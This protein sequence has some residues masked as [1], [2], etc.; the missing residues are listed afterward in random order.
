MMV[1]VLGAPDSG[2]TPLFNI[3]TGRQA[4]GGELTGEILY[5]GRKPTADFRRWVGYVVKEDPHLAHMTVF[6]TLYFSA[7]LRLPDMP[8]KIV[9]LR[10]AITLKLLG[11]SHVANSVVGDG[12][13]RGISGGEKRRVSF[14]IE[15][16]AGHA[17]IIADL[18]TNGLD[19][20]SA[21]SLM[22][23]MRFATKVGFSMMASVVQPSPQLLRLFHRVMVMSKGTIIYF[24]P[25]SQAEEFFLSAGFV[26]PKT[27]ALP[28]FIEEVTLKPELFY[29]TK[30]YKELQPDMYSPPEEEQKGEEQKQPSPSPAAAAPT[31]LPRASEPSATLPASATA[32]PAVD[33]RSTSPP[34]SAASADSNMSIVV[35][36]DGGKPVN[37]S[38][39]KD[40][41]TTQG[42]QNSI[43]ASLAELET[44]HKQLKWGEWVLPNTINRSRYHAFMVIYRAYK[45]SRFHKDVEQVLEDQDAKKARY[46]A[47]HPHKHSIYAAAKGMAYHQQPTHAAAT[48]AAPPVGGVNLAQQAQHGEDEPPARGWGPLGRMWYRQYNSSPWLQLWMNISRQT[49]LTIRNTGLWRDTWLTSL[50]MGFFLGSLFYQEGY[51]YQQ[52]RNRVGLF[53]FIL[54]YLAFN[55][56]MLVPVLAHQRGVYYNQ[57]AGGYYHGFA[58]YISHFIT[59]IPIVVVET[60]LLLLPVWGLGGLQG[61]DGGREFWYAYLVIGFNSLISRVWMILLASVS[62]NEVYADVLNTVTN[63]IF[64]K[65]CGYFI[66]ASNI[67]NGWYWVY[68]I[69]YFTYALRGLAKN[70]IWPLNDQ[71]CAQL[72]IDAQQPPC[73]DSKYETCNPAAYGNA[74]NPCIFQTGR[75]AL[76]NLYGIDPAIDK[77]SDFVN[78]VWFLLAFNVGAMLASTYVNWNEADEPE[79]PDFGNTMDLKHRQMH[80][81]IMKSGSKASQRTIS[82]S[83]NHKQ[84]EQGQGQGGS[85]VIPRAEDASMDTNTPATPS[86]PPS[87]RKPNSGANAEAAV[88]GLESGAVANAPEEGENE[89]HI[90]ANEM[91][92]SH[93][94]Q[95]MDIDRSRAPLKTKKA[96][97]QF[98]DL[99]YTVQVGKQG[100]GTEPRLL[101]NHCFG[102]AKPSMMTALMGASGAGKSTLLDVLAGKKTGGTISGDIL[103]NG[104]KADYAGS[105]SR[106]AGYVEQFDSHEAFQTVREAVKFSGR[107]RLPRKTTEKE[108]N[109][110]VDHVLEVLGISH[111]ANRMIGSPG[112]GGVSMEVR[113]KCTIAVELIM[114]PSL[115]FLDEPTTGLDSAG[116]IAV[117]TSMQL[118]AE[119]QGMT[120]VCTIHQPSAELAL[121]FDNIILMMPGGQVAYF[122]PFTMLPDWFNAHKLG[123]LQPGQNP[124]DFALDQVKKAQLGKNVDGEPVDM[125]DEFKNS[126]EAK[127]LLAE[128]DHG[129]MPEEEKRSYTPPVLAESQPTLVNQFRCLF[130]RFF[131][132]NMRNYSYI[133]IRIGLAVFM[134]FVVGTVFVKLGYDQQYS[135]QRVS[136]IFVTLIFVMFT[137]NAYL[138]DIFFLR[139][140]YFRET[141]SQM[142]SPLAFYM[143]RFV[144]DAPIVLVE[145]FILCV[146]VYFIVDLNQGNHASAFG[147][148]FLTMLGVRWTSVFFTWAIGTAV[149]LP[150]NANT[151]QSTYFNVQMILTGFIIPG[152]SIYNVWVWLY[153]ITYCHWAL[154]FLIANE[155]RSEQYQCDTDQL[156]PYSNSLNAGYCDLTDYDQP[157]ANNPMNP[158]N[159]NL[160]TVAG[161]DG[162]KCRYQCGYDLMQTYGVQWSYGKMAEYEL[163]L[164]GF[165]L[166]FAVVA[167]FALAYINHI[168]R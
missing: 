108:L 9:R 79:H 33:D 101:L 23:T 109:A 56:V 167:A 139:P 165:G 37:G 4:H 100:G 157:F 30:K 3:L 50:V 77:W 160:A 27:K 69:S 155:S 73:T 72:A 153:D 168:K 83:N 114:E 18:P 89:R 149:E 131:F 134:G 120:V 10:V 63:I 166:F 13:L 112:F 52:V 38:L 7:R 96:Y 35:H 20:A 17:C 40:A 58:Y 156:I 48:T 99:C 54:S 152:P 8:P 104:Q 95:T 138:P 26:R 39:R 93:R 41:V 91:T 113:K 124:A 76:Y 130:W 132:S 78:L 135:D 85:Q 59:Q 61:P 140:I 82:S 65:L 45:E 46:E 87:P 117:L 32:A 16:V 105:F 66:A 70:D 115:L 143:G 44:G 90:E 25:V 164:W 141:G 81:D 154:S 67:V 34:V 142:Y 12:T 122:G 19:S 51:S 28:Q 43:G 125:A 22:R 161:V 94:V 88:A 110:K 162:W 129:I 71:T 53:F 106:I 2:I 15:M 119:G 158:Y 127:G 126:A 163:V 55:A 62:P 42:S 60:L 144:A 118:L 147:L 103:V 116:A 84:Q 86:S 6:E 111:L 14:G 49:T 148:F 159:S 107:L 102:Y 21:Y 128:I 5:D 74:D 151:L 146:M 29:K 123:E 150:T 136:A 75:Q 121:M 31:I 98:K 24:G 36:D 47:Q 68:T 92:Y 57:L 1:G 64:T 145:I 97:L 133:G 11:L 137:A 80:S